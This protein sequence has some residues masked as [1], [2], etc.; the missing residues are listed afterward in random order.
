MAT[1]IT[2]FPTLAT[3]HSHLSTSPAPVRESISHEH[4][5]PPASVKG[6]VCLHPLQLRPGGGRIH[7][8]SWFEG[9]IS[10]GG[11]DLLV[12][13]AVIIGSREPG[14]ACSWTKKP[15]QKET[16]HP[17]STHHS[18]FPFTQQFYIL[19]TL[20]VSQPPN[21]GQ[22][23]GTK[24]STTVKSPQTLTPRLGIRH[25]ELGPSGGALLLGSQP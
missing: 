22:Y 4:L 13:T 24:F 19:Y 10:P 9:T 3:C 1:I 20:K 8:G 17:I 23:L 2:R 7:F 11:K 18:L 14:K 21:T 12:L 15:R 5:H 6:G 25:S 16:S